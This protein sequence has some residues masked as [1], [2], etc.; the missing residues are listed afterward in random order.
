M[1][2]PSRSLLQNIKEMQRKASVL[3]ANQAWLAQVLAEQFSDSVGPPLGANDAN[4]LLVPIYAK[5]GAPTLDNARS[6]LIYKRLAEEKGVVVRFR[7]NELGCEACLRI[8]I[9]TK[10]ECETFVAR[11]KEV[12]NEV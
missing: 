12:L 10:E 5:G 9:G 3:K 2:T 4:W 8:T 11:L 7:G 1:L 6:A